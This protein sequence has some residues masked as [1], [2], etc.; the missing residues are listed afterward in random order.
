M[1]LSSPLPSTSSVRAAGVANGLGGAPGASR[2]R[3]LASRLK[4]LAAGAAIAGAL[5]AHGPAMAQLSGGGAGATGFQPSADAGMSEAEKAASQR[6][7]DAAIAG[8]DRVLAANP[9]NVQ[10]R[11]E[12]AWTLAQAGREDEAVR[13][14]SEI[15]QEFPELPE[16]HNNLALIY[17]RRGDLKRAEAELLLAV[18]ARPGFAIGYTNLGD[19]YRKLA[20]QAYQQALKRNPNDTR[21]SSGLAMVR[22]TPAR[23]AA[24]NR[25]SGAAGRSSAEPDAPVTPP[26]VPKPPGPDRPDLD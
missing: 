11:F 1:S 3:R 8:Y 13:A 17:A 25:A 21:A 14:F 9:R 19:V 6:R 26:P 7:Y 18:D 24:D 15:A 16:P 22:G 4:L 2:P 20:E 23:G 12:R 5:A 10:A